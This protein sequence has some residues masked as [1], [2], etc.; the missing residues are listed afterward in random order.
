MW[1]D[2]TGHSLTHH[3][4][5]IWSLFEGSLCCRFPVAGSQT[6]PLL[7]GRCGGFL[8]LRNY[9]L[10]HLLTHSATDVVSII[11]VY[12]TESFLS[13]LRCHCGH[14]FSL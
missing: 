13:V 10:P 2:E 6:L 12:Y 11:A 5:S 9:S 1:R 4:G 8:P 7:R 14:T 3:V